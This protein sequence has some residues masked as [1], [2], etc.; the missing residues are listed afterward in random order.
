MAG[1]VRRSYGANTLGARRLVELEALGMARSAWGTA[2]A[3]GLAVAKDCAA[4]QGHFLP[5]TNAVRGAGGGGGLVI[6]TW[7]KNQRAAARRTRENAEGRCREAAPV[8][9]STK[10]HP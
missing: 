1:G 10:P 5:P 9:S 2:W 4:V 7:A 3:D 6:G 8:C